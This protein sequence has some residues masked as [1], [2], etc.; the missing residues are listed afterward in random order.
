MK[1]KL[2]TI[3]NRDF[4]YKKAKKRLNPRLQPIIDDFLEEPEKIKQTT[5]LLYYILGTSTP[6]A[7]MDPIDAQYVSKSQTEGQT[8]GNCEFAFQKVATERYI[9]SQI[10]PDIV[11]GGWCRL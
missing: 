8:C 4:S 5:P 11:L 7:K 2:K 1:I 6:V 9:C 10:E 3:S